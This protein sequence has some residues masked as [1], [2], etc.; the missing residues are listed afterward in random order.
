MQ[1]GWFPGNKVNNR[2]S[3]LDIVPIHEDLCNTLTSAVR[4]EE[5]TIGAPEQGIIAPTAEGSLLPG[6]GGYIT[7]LLQRHNK[8]HVTPSSSQDK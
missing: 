5:G 1:V 7:T 4:I 2:P 6:V 8:F 3:T